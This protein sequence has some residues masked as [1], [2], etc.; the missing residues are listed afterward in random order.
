MSST[1][2]R[3][4]APGRHLE[5]LTTLVPNRHTTSLPGAQWQESPKS[6]QLQGRRRRRT[7]CGLAT[8]QGKQGQIIEPPTLQG[9]GGPRQDEGLGTPCLGPNCD[10]SAFFL[11]TTQFWGELEGCVL[12][13]K[14][15]GRREE[16]PVC[17]PWS[18]QPKTPRDLPN[19][20]IAPVSPALQAVSLPSKPPGKPCAPSI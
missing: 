18:P 19:P 14:T 11:F 13:E 17:R 12:K 10:C 3:L 20:G 15:K 8:V 4:R 1:R 2:S 6:T 7:G 5:A 9:P 16:R